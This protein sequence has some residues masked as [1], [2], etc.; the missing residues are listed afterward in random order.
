MKNKIKSAI[1][2]ILLTFTSYSGFLFYYVM[3]WFKTS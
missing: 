3:I 2:F 1:Q